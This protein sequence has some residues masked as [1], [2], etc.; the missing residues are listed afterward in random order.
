MNGARAVPSSVISISMEYRWKIDSLIPPMICRFL[1]IRGNSIRGLS[2]KFRL[3]FLRIRGV[4]FFFF[5]EIGTRSVRVFSG[6]REGESS[7][8]SAL[9][10]FLPLVF[11]IKIRAR[12]NRFPHASYYSPLCARASFLSNFTTGCKRD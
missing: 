1:K 10:W 9:T 5:F 8:K 7:C 3:Q 11:L 2:R 12:D 4:S 6:W